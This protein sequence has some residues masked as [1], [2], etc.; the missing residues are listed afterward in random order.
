MHLYRYQSSCLSHGSSS[1]QDNIILVLFNNNYAHYSAHNVDDYY[2]GTQARNRW[3]VAYTLIRNPSIQGLTAS[4]LQAATEVEET[5]VKIISPTPGASIQRTD[6][7]DDDD[8][9][10]G[11]NN[12][13]ERSRPVVR[14]SRDVVDL[15]EM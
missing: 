7:D 1:R 5:E 11:F 6:D 14:D 8:A 10:L 13:H 12:D 9:K 3:L 15:L 2:T 4:R